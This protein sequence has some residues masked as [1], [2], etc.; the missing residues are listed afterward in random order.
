MWVDV[1]TLVTAVWK[2]MGLSLKMHA[3]CIWLN[4]AG[5][6][7]MLKDINLVLQWQSKVF[8]MKMNSLCG[9]L[10]L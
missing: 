9:Y 5:L 7:T 8:H 2:R 10:A 6:D 1:S 3:G 4:L